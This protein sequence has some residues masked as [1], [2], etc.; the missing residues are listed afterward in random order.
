MNS[1]KNIDRLFQE[2]FKDF[3]PEPNEN[4]WTTIQA[5]LKEEKKERKIIPI[6]LKYTGIAA[7]LFLG[8]FAL[9]TFFNLNA[10]I[11]NKIVLDPKSL[12]DSTLEKDVMD[13]QIKK[14]DKSI[15]M[16]STIA[17][18]D[19]PKTQKDEKQITTSK[20]TKNIIGK[21]PNQKTVAVY[22]RKNN[23]PLEEEEEEED[24]KNENLKPDFFLATKT[25]PQN[26]NSYDNLLSQNS[27]N[28]ILNGKSN[29]AIA[30]T[31]SSIEIGG[32]KSTPNELETILNEKES[33]KKISV[34]RK[35]K[36]E[37]RPN[38]A[39]MYANSNGINIDPQFSE[40]SKTTDNSIGFGIGINYAISKKIALRSGINKFALG[41]NTNNVTYSS[42]LKT[43]YLTNVDYTTNAMIE[44]RSNSGGTTLM[45]FE[46][47]IQKTNLG[48]INQKMGYYEVPLEIS[49]TVLDQKIGI[50]LIGGVSTL[51]LQENKIAL[52]SS[53][54]NLKL[55]EANNLNAVHFS[56]NLG[57]GFKYKFVKSFQLNFEPMVK[58]QLNTFSNTSGNNKGL[59]IGLY[60]GISY[61]F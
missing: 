25:S 48:T 14:D 53:E 45:T 44:V 54:T 24:N 41:Y 58:Y 4:T 29:L 56:S 55:G 52:I 60:S 57:V 31:D 36:W 26:T 1:N 22:N 17:I 33:D 59:L 43:T 20:H 37:I 34:E 16:T 18:T 42:G 32:L 30:K 12:N 8:S 47:S 40:N 10:P 9:T 2:R 5:A 6:W 13:V 39:A 28:E 51:F 21:A 3:E 38:I 50:S 15:K 27:K 7:S 11:Q 35:S 61:H 19:L 49:Y 46:K 23:P